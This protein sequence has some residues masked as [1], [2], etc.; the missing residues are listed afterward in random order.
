MAIADMD[1]VLL[2]DAVE[3]DK[4][5]IGRHLIDTAVVVT[6]SEDAGKELSRCRNGECPCWF[7]PRLG[8]RWS[9]KVVSC[10]LQLKDG[11][12]EGLVGDH[13]FCG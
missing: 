10:M 8:W 9:S 2:V 13:R 4:V 6:G 5:N 3:G 12:E 7:H 11:F 1:M